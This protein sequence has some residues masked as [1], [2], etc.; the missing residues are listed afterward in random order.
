MCDHLNFSRTELVTVP[1]ME[2]FTLV[3][4]AKER[5]HAK[6]ERNKSK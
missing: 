6:A 3:E 5:A 4:V 2:F 1:F